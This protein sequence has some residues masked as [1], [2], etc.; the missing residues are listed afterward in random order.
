MWRSMIDRKVT[1]LNEILARTPTPEVVA[2]L[3]RW[4]RANPNEWIRLYHGTD[5]QVPVREQG[6]RPTS[7]RRRHSLQSRGGYVSLSLFPGHA[8]V[9]A[10]LAFPQRAVPV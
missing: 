3:D 8:E 4:L 2:R 5:A 7:A 10:K 9:I 6:L 1:P